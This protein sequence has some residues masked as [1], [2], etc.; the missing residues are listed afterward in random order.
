MWLSAALLLSMVLTVLEV[1]TGRIQQLVYDTNH[2][3]AAASVETP[4]KYLI[5]V[6]LENRENC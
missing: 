5:M 4:N 6:T 2:K 1:F 3:Q